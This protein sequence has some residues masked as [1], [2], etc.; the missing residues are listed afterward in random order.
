MA[1]PKTKRTEHQCQSTEHPETARQRHTPTSNRFSSGSFR[2]SFHNKDREGGKRKVSSSLNHG[3][4]EH[5]F[6]PFSKAAKS[7]TGLQLRMVTKICSTVNQPT[8]SKRKHRF[9]SVLFFRW[10][11][12]S[13]QE[14]ADAESQFSKAKVA[15]K[16]CCSR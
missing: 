6:A 16:H 12:M 11:A 1:S 2:S 4:L 7:S 14:Y 9:R 3:L 10:Q 13:L 8:L 5:Y 15:T